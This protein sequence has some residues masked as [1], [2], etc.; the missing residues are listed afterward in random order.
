M[1]FLA[2]SWLLSL[3]SWC[4]SWLCP[5]CCPGFLGVVPGFV[6]AVV[7]GVVLGV[8]LVKV[9]GRAGVARTPSTSLGVLESNLLMRVHSPKLAARSS[10]PAEMNAG[11]FQ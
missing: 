7:L 1:L 10:L 6:L 5:G 4:C 9:Q 3:L 11:V 2:L 8:V